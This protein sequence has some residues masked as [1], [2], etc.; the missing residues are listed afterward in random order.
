MPIQCTSNLQPI[1]FISGLPFRS[2][3]RQLSLSLSLSPALYFV[4]GV[5][6]VLSVGSLTV[7]VCSRVANLS[8]FSLYIT[9]RGMVRVREKATFEAGRVWV[10]PAGE[11]WCIQNNRHTL[12]LAVKMERE[13]GKKKKGGKSNIIINRMRDQ[14]NIYKKNKRNI[15]VGQLG[16]P[17]RGGR[18]K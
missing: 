13:R 3:H 9:T 11:T 17:D 2:F 6:V 14:L 8:L 16:E 18:K 5:D 12:V 10:L 1:R 7:V 15:P 4:Y